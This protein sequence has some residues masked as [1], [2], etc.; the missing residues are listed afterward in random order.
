[1]NIT[2]F[3]TLLKIIVL[4]EM[5]ASTFTEGLVSAT[6]Q[7]HLQRC[8]ELPEKLLVAY[9]TNKCDTDME[10]VTRALDEGINVLIWSFIKFERVAVEETSG[11]MNEKVEIKTE[12]DITQYR[13]YRKKLDLM[14]HTNVVHLAAFG[15]WNGPHLPSGYAPEELY[16]AYRTFNTQQEQGH[17]GGNEPLFD[18]IDWD[19]EGHD[20]THSPTNEFT[21]EC[22]DQM[23]EFSAMAKQDGFI[24]SMAPPE[25][26][27]VTYLLNN[28][29]KIF[30]P[31]RHTVILRYHIREILSLCQPHLSRE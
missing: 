22:L 23:G 26:C 8:K 5:L 24:V 19:L 13:Q 17:L 12:L 29:K 7:Q 15:G 31:S 6:A 4:L 18:G 1:M 14:G 25:V 10:K 16:Q 20:N 9:T 27:S 11:R 30:K 21:K 2:T 28:V 3:F